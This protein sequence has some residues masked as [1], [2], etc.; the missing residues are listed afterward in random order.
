MRSQIMAIYP[1]SRRTDFTLRH[2]C[3]CY[4]FETGLAHRSDAR[5]IETF[6]PQCQK[7]DVRAELHTVTCVVLVP[8]EVK[9]I[10]IASFR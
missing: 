7:E 5:L 1:S 10:R 3:K 4:V 9:K 2:Q 6:E 8:F